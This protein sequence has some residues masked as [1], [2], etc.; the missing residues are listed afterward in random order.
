MAFHKL[1]A[2]TRQRIHEY[3]EHRYQ[4]KVFDED[5]ILGELSAPLR[6][7]RPPGGASG[8]RLQ[9]HTA[10]RRWWAGLQTAPWEARPPGLQGLGSF[11]KGYGH[12]LSTGGAAGSLLGGGPSGAHG[13]L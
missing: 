2:D 13:E 4:G 12:A 10:G 3:Y 7:V 5:S 11:P 6:E 8:A 9:G 1:P